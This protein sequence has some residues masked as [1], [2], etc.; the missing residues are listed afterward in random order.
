MMTLKKILIPAAVL[1]LVA[2]TAP[3][4]L[5]AGESQVQVQSR[6]VEFDPSTIQTVDGARA[7]Y[8]RIRS[9]AFDV[10]GD[11]YAP[12]IGH[13]MWIRVRCAKQATDVAIKDLNAPELNQ[14][15]GRAPV[16]VAR[17]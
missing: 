14:L 1:T 11:E 7:L 9:A 8:R 2:G 4:A 16:R 5:A 15:H 6:V 10:C 13:D 12:L 3:A 17:N